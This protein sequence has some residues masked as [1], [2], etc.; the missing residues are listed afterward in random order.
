MRLM[1][2]LSASA[3]TTSLRAGRKKV[4]CV[5]ATHSLVVN[6]ML[7]T[8]R[9]AA[10]GE[11][12]ALRSSGHS[13]LTVNTNVDTRSAVV[14]LKLKL[15]E[16]RQA[17]SVVE[18]RRPA[19]LRSHSM[20]T[21]H[22]ATLRCSEAPHD[23]PPVSFASR[24]TRRETIQQGTAQGRRGRRMR[25][26]PQGEWWLRSANRLRHAGRVVGRVPWQ[27][28]QRGLV[29][30]SC[31]ACQSVAKW[32][33]PTAGAGGREPVSGPPARCPPTAIRQGGR[34]EI[35]QS[36]RRPPYD[37]TAAAPLGPTG[38][39]PDRLADPPTRSSGSVP[40]H[41]AAP[42]GARPPCRH[43]NRGGRR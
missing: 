6:R 28:G 39:H 2:E 19:L 25:R 27:A 9:R 43:S 24:M 21:A 17:T 29:P 33:G 14:A 18:W 40:S 38:S 16:S 15:G 37:Q 36:A 41:C 4:R 1:V 3:H 12:S 32:R 34:R 22:R 23:Q 8:P 42:P 26:H 11:S 35:A 5:V 30:G 20:R 10:P 31:P 7:S 13:P